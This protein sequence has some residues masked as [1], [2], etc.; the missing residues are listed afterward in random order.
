MR[1]P[2]RWPTALALGPWANK[3]T[4]P[5]IRTKQACLTNPTSTEAT[6]CWRIVHLARHNSRTIHSA[7]HP[8]APV[9]LYRPTLP[10]ILSPPWAGN[11]MQRRRRAPATSLHSHR[12]SSNRCKRCSSSNSSIRLSVTSIPE[13]SLR[14]VSH[15][16]KRSFRCIIHPSFYSFPCAVNSRDSRALPARC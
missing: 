15:Y 3:H 12:L 7:P 4:R 5:C 8:R 9:C 10:R 6:Q 13:P 11:T 16:C 1:T 14:G 2:I